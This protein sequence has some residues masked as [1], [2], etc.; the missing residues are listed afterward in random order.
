MNNKAQTHR[1][2]FDSP[3]PT[4]KTG[5]PAVLNISDLQFRQAS[6]P[7]TTARHPRMQYNTVPKRS[8]YL[9]VPMLHRPDESYYS[10]GQYLLRYRESTGNHIFPSALRGYSRWSDNR[11]SSQEPNS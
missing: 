1:L 4:G 5:L 2:F 11:Y 3:K 8:L 7:T 9:R 6:E 10:A